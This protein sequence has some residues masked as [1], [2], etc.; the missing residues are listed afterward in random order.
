MATP[1]HT[2]TPCLKSGAR[3]TR[4]TG[5]D[6]L[7]GLHA[8]YRRAICEAKRER[9]FG[10]IDDE[11]VL[12]VVLKFTAEQAPYVRER[13]WHPSQRLQ[14]QEDGSLIVRFQAS[15]EFEIVR[16][17]RGRGEDVEVLEPPALR[18]AV[19]QYLQEAARHYVHTVLPNG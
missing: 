5:S 7:Q 15:G 11:E 14:A 17:V 6:D 19:A 9:A 3:E 12:E 4:P 2:I 1:R 8:A 10:I 18:Q 16:W 13:V